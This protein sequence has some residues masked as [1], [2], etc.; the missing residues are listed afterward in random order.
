MDWYL[1]VL[2]NYVGF[3]GRARRKEYWMFY[4]VTLLITIGL[5]IIDTVTGTVSAQ[6]GVDDD[7]PD[8]DQ[9]GD[10][11]EHPVFLAARAAREAHVVPEHFQIPIH[12]RSPK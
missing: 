2:R 5:V 10:Q 7:Q 3:S 6:Y 9:Q 1:K 8:R 12:C 4:L 11:I